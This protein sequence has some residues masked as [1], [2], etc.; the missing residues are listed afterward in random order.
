MTRRAYHVAYYARTIHKRRE[1]ARYF[2]WRR[3]AREMGID[4]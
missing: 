4:V 2:A 3:R 1:R